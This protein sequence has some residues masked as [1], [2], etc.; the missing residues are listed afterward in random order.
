VTLYLASAHIRD[1]VT[2]GGRISDRD[3]RSAVGQIRQGR[4]SEI[5]LLGQKSSRRDGWRG[6]E[7]EEGE[8]EAG[9]AENLVEGLGASESENSDKNMRIK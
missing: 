4:D 7:G 3:P 6:G 5:V 1:Y 8:W 9:S 2:E